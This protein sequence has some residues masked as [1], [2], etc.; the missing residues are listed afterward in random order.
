MDFG[1]LD[2]NLLVALD[3]LFAERERFPRRRAIAFEPIG[4]QRRAGAAAGS[5]S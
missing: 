3:A 5:L 2:L 1:G 4:H